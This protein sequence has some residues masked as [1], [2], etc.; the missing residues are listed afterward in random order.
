VFD[1][2][3]SRSVRYGVPGKR[4]LTVS[5]PDMPHLGIWTKPGAGFIC[6]EPWQGYASPEAFDGELAE[7]PGI[8]LIPPGEVRAFQTEINNSTLDAG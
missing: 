7:K 4:S 5:F 6:I 8:V 3:A 1:S 2:L